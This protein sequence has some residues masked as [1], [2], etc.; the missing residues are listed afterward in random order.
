MTELEGIKLVLG[1]MVEMLESLSDETAELVDKC[2][3]PHYAQD[4]HGEV[5]ARSAAL[6]ATAESLRRVAEPILGKNHLLPL[7]AKDQA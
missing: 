7:P 3:R 1:R 4:Y 6:V 2:L 5:A